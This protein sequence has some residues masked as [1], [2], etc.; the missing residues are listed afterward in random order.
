MKT[1]ELLVWHLGT[2]VG[3][4]ICSLQ[5]VV[6]VTFSKQGRRCCELCLGREL[7]S[8]CSPSIPFCRWGIKAHTFQSEGGPSLA[9]EP[10]FSSS[11]TLVNAVEAGCP[12]IVPLQKIKC[13]PSAQTPL[14]SALG[15]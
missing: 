8:I 3:H 10:S 5:V 1:N 11:S 2:E 12:L 13:R 9:P 14:H 6:A 15:G 4:R 7:V